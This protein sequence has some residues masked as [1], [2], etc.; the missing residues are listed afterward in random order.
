MKAYATEAIRNLAVIGHG[1]AGKTQLISSLLYV[2][3]ATTRWGK[4]DEGTTTTDH[5]E[6]SIARKITLNIA[7]AH[8]E[9]KE[10]KLNLNDTP[11]YAAFVSHARP[12]CRVADCGVVVVDGVKGVEVQ[13]EKVWNYSNEFMLPRLMVVTKLDKEHSDIG[14][15]LD[16]AHNVFKRAIVP[17]TLPIGKEYNFKG[18]VDVVHMKAYEFDEHGKAKE[19]DIPAEGRDVVDKTRE[20]LVELVA[21]SDD[22][23]LEKYF[24][25]GTLD[26]SDVLPNIG[27]AI[28]NSKLC[29]VFAVSTINLVGL[30]TLLDHIIE[31]APDPAHHEAEHGKNEKGEPESRKYS[32]TEPFSAYCFRTIADPFAGRINVFKIFSGKIGTDA[33]VYNSTRSTSERLGALHTMQGKQLDK[34]PEANA[35][36]I[37]A[38]VKLKETQTGDTLCDKARAIIYDPVQYPEAAI[39]FAIEPKSRQDEEK[40]SVAI[41]KILEEDPA[42]TFT[43][44]AQT[45]EFLLAGSGQVHVETIVDKL[46]K[47]YNVEVMLHPPKVPY[48]ETITQRAEVQ[49]RHKKQTGGRGQFGDCKVIFEPLPRGGGFTFEDKIFGGSVP[50]QFR[51]AIEKGIIEAASHGAIA[52]YPLVDF[53][54]QLIDGSYHNVDSD[55]H[56]FRAAGRKAFRNAMEKVKP[57]LLEPIMDVEITAPQECSG[58]IMGDLNSRRGRVQGMDTWGKNQLIKAQVPMAEMLNYQSTLNSMTAARGSFH[59][60]FSHYDPVPGQLAQKIVQQARDE[61]RIRGEEEE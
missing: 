40:I 55:E 28:A 25:Q 16:S 43:R 50:Q 31:F 4:V 23:L 47:R 20:R 13:T 52:G 51:P 27:A 45:K 30:S 2:A 6:D 41:H 11:G 17:F 36:D 24:D 34:V 22:A 1:D 39:A 37:V 9:H 8:L 35:G 59:M 15:A 48:K 10:T 61:G 33:T 32:G 18:V 29:P 26:D 5:D 14:I 54:V 53:K 19:I 12:A 58:D 60:Q 21:E 42:L 7:L 44:D 46:K 38:C 49:G 3:G 56:S 57:T